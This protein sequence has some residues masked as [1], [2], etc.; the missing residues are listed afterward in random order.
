MA[1]KKKKKPRQGPSGL[2]EAVR[3]IVMRA[4]LGTG[5]A[6]GARK[7]LKDRKK[8]TDDIVTRLQKGK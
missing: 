4:G 3:E 6:E 7:A 2:G 8:E 5:M 1:D